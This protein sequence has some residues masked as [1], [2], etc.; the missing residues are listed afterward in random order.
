M[1]DSQGLSPGDTGYD[2][3]TDPASPSYQGG[4]GPVSTTLPV[5]DWFDQNSPATNPL[6]VGSQQPTGNTLVPRNDPGSAT[7]APTDINS[8]FTQFV[9]SNPQYAGGGQAAIDAFGQAYPQY[10]GIIAWD[11]TRQIYES[12]GGY[13]TNIPG[14]PQ[15]GWSLTPTQPETGSAATGGNDP[16]NPTPFTYAPFTD[17]FS[18]PNFVAPT[19]LTEQNDPGYQERLALGAQTLQNSAASQGTL[20]TGQTLNNLNQYAQ[21]FA[22]NDFNNV[23]NQALTQYQQNS[24]N[25]FQQYTQQYEQYLN[26]YQQALQGYN[27][28]LGA[29]QQAFSDTL[30]LSSQVFSQNQQNWQN[31]FNTTQLGLNAAEASAAGGQANANAAGGYI[32]GAGNAAA[33]GTVGAANGNLYGLGTLTNYLQNQG[34]QPFFQS[35][36]QQTNEG[37]GNPFGLV[38]NF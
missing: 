20:L 5:G 4:G 14:N 25:N 1:A 34:T 29:G 9:N 21:N 36:Y 10:N 16:L 26:G 23:Y 2:P 37:S 31:Q 6:V 38:T 11:P 24:Q 12:Q 32:T 19:G 7:A 33:A 18:N 27:T 17:T 22:T 28:N 35:P 30:G 8:A 3:T 13:F 15:G